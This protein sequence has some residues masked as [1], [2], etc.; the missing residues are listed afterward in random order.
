MR[1]VLM[2]C[3]DDLSFADVDPC[4]Y[5]VEDM[6]ILSRL[7]RVAGEVTV[8]LEKFEF[9]VALAKI[10]SFLWEEYCDWYI[11][12]VKA[13]L[14]DA[15]SPSRLEAKFVLT[16]VLSKAMQLLHPFMPFLTEEVFRSLPRTED[17]ASIMV[18]AWPAPSDDRD[19]PEQERQVSMLMDAIRA[20]RNVRV[21][22][23]VP[24]SKK[25]AAIL[26]TSSDE[27]KRLFLDGQ[28][29]L[30]RLAGINHIQTET[31]RDQ[32]PATAVVAVFAGGELFIPLGELIDIEKERDRLD[33]EKQNLEREIER[34]R[35]KL[36]NEEFVGRAP[37]KV[38]DAE[39]EKADKYA[40]MYAGIL[41][42]IRL[43]DA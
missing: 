15:N 21:N 14:Y 43:L 39:R 7:N 40:A 27:T 35:S 37:A 12:I 26:V 41:E 9:G 33:K 17:V 10:Y 19:F 8:N 34:V 28:A 11:E 32:I 25:A 22:M 6:W 31:S 23:G 36:S 24:P 13:R 30:D 20:V 38:I 3:E 4:K 29:F 5:T 2:N 18:S 1:F 42:R 16:D